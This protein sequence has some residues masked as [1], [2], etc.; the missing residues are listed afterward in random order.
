[1]RNT[2]GPR[3]TLAL[4]LGLLVVRV[5]IAAFE[6]PT[7]SADMQAVL[8]AMDPRTEQKL[9][10]ITGTLISDFGLRPEKVTLL[11]GA[12]VTVPGVSNAISKAARGL[13][14]GATLFVVVAL[15]LSEDGPERAI[16]T[17]DFDRSQPWSGL[18][19]ELIQ[20]FA[21]MRSD[22]NVWLFVPQCGSPATK[23]AQSSDYSFA[24]GSD[25]PRAT[26]RF[27][28]R[29]R[30]DA[31]PGALFAEMLG[32][33]LQRAASDPV[34]RKAAQ[35][36]GA[37][38]LNAADVLFALRS[39]SPD[40]RVSADLSRGGG[41]QL[42]V[43]PRRTRIDADKLD[44]RLQAAQTSAD[45]RNVL[46]D[47]VEQLRA[48]S[49]DERKQAA[50]ILRK[51][52]TDAGVDRSY[53]ML[54]IQALGDA[55]TDV[56][57][58]ALA[59]AY[60]DS[61]DPSF[62][63]ALL[64]EWGTVAAP[65]DSSLI[66]DALKDKAPEVQAAAI[67][68]GSRKQDPEISGEIAQLALSAN[69]AATRAAAVRAIPDLRGQ[70]RY[71]SVLLKALADSAENVRAEAAS[72][73]ARA[74]MT[75]EA[76]ERLRNVMRNDRSDRVQEAATYA[77]G[78]FVPQLSRRE[79]EA[80]AAEFEQVAVKEAAPGLRVAAL[81]GLGE[82]KQQASAPAIERIAESG[83]S[84]DTQ[85]AAIQALAKIASPTSHPL[86]SK[87]AANPELHPRMR[88]AAI[89]GL[90]QLPQDEAVQSLWSLSQDENPDVAIAARTGLGSRPRYTLATHRVL[91]D[92]EA[93]TDLRVL[94]ARLLGNSADSRGRDALLEQLEQVAATPAALPE[95]L[96]VALIQF[97]DPQSL[98]LL[99]DRIDAQRK[100]KRPT[101]L[102]AATALSRIGTPAARTRLS[103]AA[104]DP[105]PEVRAIVAAGLPTDAS[106]LRVLDVLAQDPKPEVRAATAQ[107]LGRMDATAFRLQQLAQDDDPSVRAAAIE[108]LR[109]RRADPR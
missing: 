86:L 93:P 100:W 57:A 85:L 61:K 20:K 64:E 80:L 8:F 94:S 28:E 35:V 88:V 6:R 32:L 70:G 26:V 63:R 54:A 9:K 21:S 49:D 75:H 72:S 33:T 2:L 102:L 96:V 50:R 69:D 5:S 59:D 101:R 71:D 97:K 24:A 46:G 30:E 7:P 99:A 90:G 45:L 40:L 41:A 81:W 91:R 53:R 39:S 95:A 73:L 79:Q 74:P 65:G 67:H 78:K 87:T 76:V 11:A 34:G 19:A 38:V 31:A 82:A 15:G 107:T 13:E 51:Y 4:V 47:F 16:V 44:A 105:D 29:P 104:R 109:A 17:A 60:Q 27:C 84:D 62:R 92:P 23:A 89:S 108:A 12:N 1:M 103:R 14:P 25:A 42:L 3:M 58:P 37:Y 52:I 22:L 10:D 43:Q 98:D 66:E 18:S 55:P 36:E 68:A 83:A 48:G 106:S 77:L 56:A